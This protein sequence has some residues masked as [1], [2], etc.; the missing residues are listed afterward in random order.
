MERTGVLIER[1]LQ[2]HNDNAEAGK[3]LVTAQLLVA[4]LQFLAQ[5]GTSSKKVSVV[6]PSYTHNAPSATETNTVTLQNT[7]VPAPPVKEKPLQQVTAPPPV[8]QQ[9]PE[10]VRPAQY[11]PINEIP[12]MLHQ[13]AKNDLNELMSEKG[14]ESVNEKLKN[15]NIELGA[16]LQSIPVKDLKRAIGINDRYV[17]INELFRG[18]EVMYERSIKTINSFSILAEAEYWIKRELKLKLSWDE[19][20][21]S[22]KTFDQLVRR[23]FS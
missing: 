21:E 13:P 20:S 18:D 16:R 22:A 1:L 11:D 2:Q 14:A 4:E 23:R 15:N 19:E 17:F 5:A 10:P 6:V 3:M 8:P 7:P 12:T 9:V